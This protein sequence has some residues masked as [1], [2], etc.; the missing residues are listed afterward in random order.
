MQLAELRRRR[1]EEQRACPAGDASVTYTSRRGCDERVPPP[2]V[3]PT[4]EE[5]IRRYEERAAAGLPLFT[6][7]DRR[8]GVA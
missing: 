3:N 7:A 2:S 6:A 4:R 5:R 1:G 8:Q